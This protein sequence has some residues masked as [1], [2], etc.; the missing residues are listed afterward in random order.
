MTGFKPAGPT[1]SSWE[2]E[3]QDM[4]LPEGMDFEDMMR[5]AKQMQEDMLREM[6]QTRVDASAGGGIVAV[7]MNGAKE[8]VDIRIDPDIIKSGDIEMLQDL[9]LAAVNEASRKVDVSCGPGHAPQ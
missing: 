7:A 2:K 8:L 4:K 1:W 5:Q 6:Q 9:I 3:E